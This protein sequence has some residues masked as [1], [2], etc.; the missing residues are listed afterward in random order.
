MQ[1]VALALMGPQNAARIIKF[2]DQQ[3]Q[4]EVTM[5]M[6]RLKQVPG[7]LADNLINT[8]TAAFI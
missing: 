2:M 5:R 8:V 3:R 1:A 6:S 4:A 7:D